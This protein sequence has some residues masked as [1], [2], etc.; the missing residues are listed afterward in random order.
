M[1]IAFLPHVYVKGYYQ[2]ESWLESHHLSLVWSIS[3]SVLHETGAINKC[4]CQNGGIQ[5][6]NTSGR[7]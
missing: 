5:Q 3:H 4:P 1:K 7:K 6:H 2:K